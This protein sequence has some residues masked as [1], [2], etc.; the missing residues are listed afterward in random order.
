MFF[1]NPS[2]RTSVWERPEDLV[3]RG[4]VD[5]MVGNAPDAVVQ[6]QAALGLATN[7]VNS[8]NSMTGAVKREVKTDDEQPIPAKKMKKDEPPVKGIQVILV[9][10]PFLF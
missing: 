6:S 8:E 7:G 9:T 10:P 5:K 1:Y 3:G 2:S 4:D